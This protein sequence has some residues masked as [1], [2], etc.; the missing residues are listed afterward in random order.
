MKQKRK[1]AKP[2]RKTLSRALKTARARRQI[3]RAKVVGKLKIAR[4]KLQRGDTLVCKI[5]HLLTQ[6][7]SNAIRDH[8]KTRVPKGCDVLVTSAGVALSVLEGDVF[9]FGNTGKIKIPP[10]PE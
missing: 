10:R 1:P 9:R 6:E 5:E 3:L 8:L 2:Y 4:L 7:Q